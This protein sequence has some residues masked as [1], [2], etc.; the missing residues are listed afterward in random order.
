VGAGGVAA[1]A[2]GGEAACGSGDAVLAGVTS[3]RAESDRLRPLTPETDTKAQDTER[4]CLEDS[5]CTRWPPSL[6]ETEPPA[7]ADEESASST[8]RKH[9]RFI[10]PS[11]GDAGEKLR[12]G[13]PRRRRA[14]A[15]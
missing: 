1:G 2:G 15:M 11:A 13:K 3:S 7:D 5:M 14:F 4:Q 9:N 8:A 10:G 6:N 12:E